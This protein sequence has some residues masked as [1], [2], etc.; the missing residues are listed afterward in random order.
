MLKR[1]SLCLGPRKQRTREDKVHLRNSFIV[2]ELVDELDSF[3]GQTGELSAAAHDGTLKSGTRSAGEDEPLLLTDIDIDDDF[4]LLEDS[5]DGG[6]TYYSG[7]RDSTG[8]RETV[9]WEGVG[10]IRTPRSKSKAKH[11]RSESMREMGTA[12]LLEREVRCDSVTEVGRGSSTNERSLDRQMSTPACYRELRAIKSS[13]RPPDVSL[14]NRQ[15]HI[16]RELELDRLHQQWVEYERNSRRGK[17]TARKTWSKTQSALEALRGREGQCEV[18]FCDAAP[19]QPAQSAADYS[20]YSGTQHE[21]TEPPVARPLF[22]DDTS[23]GTQQTSS[24]RCTDPTP[25]SP[26]P[27]ALLEEALAVASRFSDGNQTHHRRSN[28]MGAFRDRISSSPRQREGA[29]GLSGSLQKSRTSGR[30][31]P[32]PGLPPTDPNSV[33]LKT[34]RA[35]ASQ[36]N[37]RLSARPP[38]NPV[39][40]PRASRNPVRAKNPAGTPLRTACKNKIPKLD[41][42][43]PRT[44]SGPQRVPV[45][46][47]VSRNRAQSASGSTA[48]P[49]GGDTGALRAVPLSTPRRAPS[50]Y[51]SAEHSPPDIKFRKGPLGKAAPSPRPGIGPAVR[52]PLQKAQLSTPRKGYTPRDSDSYA[53]SKTTRLP[54]S[55]PQRLQTSVSKMPSKKAMGALSRGVA[56]TARVK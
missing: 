29:R 5:P 17:K 41:T 52:V 55:A 44:S 13:N 25:I 48:L 18:P 24:V 47:N 40:T 7:G 10:L 42:D 20:S 32:A 39:E 35:G 34:P 12:P 46:R 2:D 26:T 27:D 43:K 49:G 11:T 36:R 6:R 3:D 28:S 23:L 56:S 22:Q 45:K 14:H 37:A 15:W 19:D 51:K 30:L 1:L 54:F 53:M 8:H 38:R 4:N 21:Q 33:C 50:S 16:A 9:R 31:D